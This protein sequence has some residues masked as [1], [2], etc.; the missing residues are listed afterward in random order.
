MLL[1]PH[2][3]RVRFEFVI[4]GVVGAA[5]EYPAAW[6]RGPAFRWSFTVGGEVVEYRRCGFALAVATAAGLA[7]G[8]WAYAPGPDRQIREDLDRSAEVNPAWQAHLAECERLTDHPARSPLP[9]ITEPT[10][11]WVYV[12]DGKGVQG[13]KIGWTGGEPA[14]RLADLQTGSPV[15]LQ[16]RYAI[17]GSRA[18]EQAIHLLLDE[19]RTRGEW[20]GKPAKVDALF[21]R[22]YQDETRRP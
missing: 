2:Y 4:D 11:G 21:R 10:P 18:D 14:K 5:E 15:E 16:V 17:R 8:T 7:A 9:A 3:E 12:I 6:L 13:V 19:H 20:F 1:P 22:I